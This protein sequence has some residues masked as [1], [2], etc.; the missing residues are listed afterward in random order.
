[1][2]TILDLASIL[3]NNLINNINFNHLIINKIIQV[4]TKGPIFKKNNINKN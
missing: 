1:M 3:V 4:N 2:K